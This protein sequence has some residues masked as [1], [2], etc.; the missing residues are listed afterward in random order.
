MNEDGPEGVR[1]REQAARH[2]STAPLPQP[3]PAKDA[4]AKLR[5]KLRIEVGWRYGWFILSATDGE[6]GE[7]LRP[8]FLFIVAS[9]GVLQA[10]K[11][12]DLKE[13]Y[14][15]E[16]AERQV[17]DEDEKGKGLGADIVI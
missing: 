2:T 3:P 5:R 9:M 10:E 13:L 6:R 11:L 16:E 7:V 14:P 17:M 8:V 4:A 1:L 12:R 15:D